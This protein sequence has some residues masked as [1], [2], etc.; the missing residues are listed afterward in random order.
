ME[1]VRVSKVISIS[2]AHLLTCSFGYEV[3][4]VVLDEPTKPDCTSPLINNIGDELV[5]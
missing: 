2:P 4:V 3:A 5:S 1:N